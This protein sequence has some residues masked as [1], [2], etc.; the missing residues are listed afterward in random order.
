METMA[1]F[2]RFMSGKMEN[3]EKIRMLIA[4]KG[5]RKNSQVFQEYLKEKKTTK[6]K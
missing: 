4:Q 6:V 3:L 2:A 1:Q 5:Q